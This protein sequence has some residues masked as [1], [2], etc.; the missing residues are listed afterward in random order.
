[1]PDPQSVRLSTGYINEGLYQVARDPNDPQ[2]AWLITSNRKCVPVTPEGLETNG[3]IPDPDYVE[4]KDEETRLII[5]QTLSTWSHDSLSSYVKRMFLFRPL[6]LEGRN[7]N[8][9]NCFFALRA[10]SS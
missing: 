2:A 1:M 3:F 5:P 4:K 7:R 8:K 9:I 6:L 10:V